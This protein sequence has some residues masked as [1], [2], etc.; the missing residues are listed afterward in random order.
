MQ[1]MKVSVFMNR[2]PVVFTEQLP[3]EA[4][5]ER[6]L[7]SRQRGGPVVD[8]AQRVIGFLS[9]Q[10]CLAA[11]LRGTYHNEMSATV[12]DC[13]YHGDVL[14]VFADDSIADVA[15]RMDANKPKV[16]P[17]LDDETKQLVGV[18]TRTDVLAAIDS[19][20]QDSYRQR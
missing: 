5:V 2:R 11:M 6:L 15:Q 10:D 8:A 20:F 13:M 9:E 4:A 19:F 14:T 7:Q 12:G 17:V 1:S 16:Y 18:I 3:V